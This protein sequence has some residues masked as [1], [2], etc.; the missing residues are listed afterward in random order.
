MPSGDFPSLGDRNSAYRRGTVL[1]L[2]VAEVFIL[3][4][5][6][7]MLAFLA[8]A[9][10]WE[11]EAYL[12]LTETQLRERLKEAEAALEDVQHVVEKFEESMS[13]RRGTSIKVPSQVETLGGLELGATSASLDP[14]E[15][16][17]P[18]HLRVLPNQVETLMM[19]ALRVPEL[20]DERAE[21][22]GPGELRP[23]EAAERLSRDL[24][25]LREKGHNPPCWYQKVPDGKGGTREK[26]YYTFNVEVLDRGMILRRIPTPPGG[27]ADDEDSPDL[28]YAEE[29]AKLP[30][31]RIPDGV[32]LDDAA[33]AR[34]LRPIHD[35][36]KEERVRSYSCIFWARVWDMTSAGAKDRW[37]RAHDGVLESLLGT[38]LVSDGPVQGGTAVQ[39]GDASV[40]SRQ[41]A[42]PGETRESEQAFRLL[43]QE[44]LV[45]WDLME[46]SIPGWTFKEWRL[47]KESAPIFW[48]DLVCVQE[49]RMEVHLIWSVNLET[50][51]VTALSQAARD[52]EQSHARTSPIFP[53]S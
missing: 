41:T 37:K 6:L 11:N 23:E 14:A 46:G 26:P 32:V 13:E 7:L 30:F 17:L 45:A 28:T 12:A 19:E 49:P 10:E 42:G 51:T 18:P 40:G 52:L 2:T 29:A 39:E 3:L 15:A 16:R 48:I 20:A 8:L 4:L 25:V 38:Y 53:R 50:R 43:P 31:D 21:P 47:V 44:S 34:Y 27:A 33:V 9:Q 1:G 5:F 22:P 36:G 35:A 24:R